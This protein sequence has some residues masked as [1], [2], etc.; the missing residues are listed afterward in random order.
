MAQA[1]SIQNTI[2][3]T[4]LTPR[5]S[6]TTTYTALNLHLTPY[7]TNPSSAYFPDT[8]TVIHQSQTTQECIEI[9][10]TI[11][12]NSKL[13]EID[14]DLDLEGSTPSIATP[15]PD[16]ISIDEAKIH[17]FNAYTVCLDGEGPILTLKQV[18]KKTESYISEFN[19]WKLK[20]PPKMLFLLLISLGMAFYGLFEVINSNF[21]DQFPLM[22]CTVA[23][24]VPNLFRS[25]QN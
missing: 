3:N 21:N 24:T 5:P 25:K 17:L 10:I 20:Y 6:I 14:D 1:K 18:Q 9:P 7:S 4:K 15:N 11:R 2:A 19:H 13:K 12:E 8:S 16:D 23:S 22:V